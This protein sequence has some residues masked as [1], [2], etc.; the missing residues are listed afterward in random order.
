ME[1]ML[2]H[3]STQEIIF[4]HRVKGWSKREIARHIEVSEATIRRILAKPENQIT[5]PDS[6]FDL[7]DSRALL[8]TTHPAAIEEVRD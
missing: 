8:E 4:L 2:S 3:N 7:K 1:I 5:I 6:K